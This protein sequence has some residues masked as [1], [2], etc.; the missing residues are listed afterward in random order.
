MTSGS[1]NRGRH[2]RMVFTM[3]ANSA[4]PV[5]LPTSS[6]TSSYAHA[7]MIRDLNSCASSFVISERTPL[8]WLTQNLVRAQW[9][10]GIYTWNHQDS[11][12]YRYIKGEGSPVADTIVS[13]SPE[14]AQVRNMM[15]WL[16]QQS[17]S[18]RTMLLKEGMRTIIHYLDVERCTSYSFHSLRIL[19]T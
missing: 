12:P 5:Q 17:R 7:F 13:V 15:D 8:N 9:Y 2:E 16:L 1:S 3:S 14:E 11:V 4:S 18:S 6:V 19:P 10:Q